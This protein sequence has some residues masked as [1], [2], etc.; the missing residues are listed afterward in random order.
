MT[1]K[2]SYV[3]L[4]QRV[5][6][7]EKQA[8]EQKC[9]EMALRESKEL[10]E[11]TFESQ[12]DA[13][14]ILDANVPPKITECN[15]AAEKV[16]G[17][18]LQ[19]M[20]GRTTEFLHISRA[21]L[22]EFQK[23]LYPSIAK[24]G[25]FHL[26]DFMMKRKDGT[27][28]PSEHTVVPLNNEKAE[29]TGWV[30][31]V[32]DITKRREAQRALEQSAERFR[33]LAERI[34]DVFWIGTPQFDKQIYVSPA[35]ERIW[36]KTRESLYASPRSFFDSIHPQD[37]DRVIDELE[38][39]RESVYAIEYRVIKP[40]GSVRW[41][42]DR[43]FPIKD[44]QGKTVM[45]SG[46]ATD[47]TERKEMENK[48]LESEEKYRV[49]AESVHSSIFM[50]DYQGR[51]LY[52][53]RFGTDLI[54]KTQAEILGTNLTE[55]FGEEDSKRMIS[56]IQL[57][58]TGRHSL[59]SEYTLHFMEEERHFALVL[60]PIMGAEGTVTMVVGVAHDVTDQ[61][62]AKQK[63]QESESRMRAL[64]DTLTESLMLVDAEGTILVINDTAARR[65]GQSV[66]ESIGLRVN[67]YLPEDVA[68]LRKNLGEKVLLSS[69]GLRFQDERQG[70]FYDN[71]I[72]PV[73]DEKGKVK[74]LAIF[75]R[76]IT[77]E[78]HLLEA[79]WKSE[80]HYRLV[81]E[82]AATGIGIGQ[83]DGIVIEANEVLLE[84]AGYTREELGRMNLSDLYADP[85]ERTRLIDALKKE[86]SVRDW[87]VELK[88]KD[89]TVYTALLNV[90]MVELDGREVLFTSL[91]D[92]T[93][94]REAERALKSREKQLEIKTKNLE[95]ANTAL[96]V[97]LNSREEDK[98]EVENKVLVN[99]KR[100]I[101]P[102]LSKLKNSGLDERQATYLEIL[103]SNL[104][105]I[106]SPFATRL[107]SEY[108]GLTP[109]E[110]QVASLVKEG[111]TTKEIAELL[112]SSVSAIRFHRE[113]VRK[114]IGL[115]N[116][117]AN[118]RSRLL[119]LK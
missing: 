101:E 6:E 89:G 113:N 29:Q 48:L 34:D 12:N 56:D 72:T 68:T 79:L 64:L 15:P 87:E 62:R 35:Y 37:R 9:R 7:L 95:E 102:Y 65:L 96:R 90:E 32:R 40:D 50:H 58:F 71:S 13:I 74:E 1:R 3:E 39:N 78:K 81:F 115:T 106:V 88:R 97:L 107:S 100:L 2:P 94:L 52:I 45:V 24:Q 84:T 112:N 28:F 16:F 66:E 105:D 38:K 42:L 111:K 60:S 104:K 10:L 86:G 4:E 93:L 80:K 91:S 85:H 92:I 14:F 36:G 25:F 33:L 69:K 19:E 76:D 59:E 98:I 54:G 44:K 55:W 31:V 57:V 17:Y 117:K 83:L 61:K 51:F 26:N 63:L 73:F 70:K 77:E 118:L 75:A 22:Q 27:L 47:H 103:E 46:V 67:E 119:S 30:S 8:V 11:K 114:K 110:I 82:K 49:L 109:K 108:L 23:Q 43:C 99:V 5:A 21:A 53:N 18:T 116:Q 20:P 41:V